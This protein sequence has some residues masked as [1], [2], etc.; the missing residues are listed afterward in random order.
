M[1]CTRTPQRTERRL[2]PELF[3]HS[4]ARA[5]AERAK[6]ATEFWTWVATATT[7]VVRL[8]REREAPAR[9]KLARPAKY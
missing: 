7:W 4:V 5:R 8:V 6:A 3:D 1:D 2:T 9:R